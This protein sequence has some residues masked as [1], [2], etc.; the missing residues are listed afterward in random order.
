MATVPGSQL[1]TFSH[2]ARGVGTLFHSDWGLGMLPWKV[3]LSGKAGI[4][5][6]CA[7]RRNRAWPPFDSQFSVSSPSNEEKSVDSR[8][9]KTSFPA[10]GKGRGFV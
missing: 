4:P 2:E 6:L 7:T 5:S 9:S 8:L 10:P 1:G 3:R